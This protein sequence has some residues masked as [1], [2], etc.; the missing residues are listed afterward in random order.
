MKKNKIP[1]RQSVKEKS[2]ADKVHIRQLLTGVRGTMKLLAVAYQRFVA[3]TYG[4]GREPE[5]ATVSG[6]L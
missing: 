6:N 2:R 1:A 5:R 3:R 4:S